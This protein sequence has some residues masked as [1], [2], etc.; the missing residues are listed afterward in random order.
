VATT[1]TRR[2]GAGAQPS[3]L[4]ARAHSPGDADRV[5][6]GATRRRLLLVDPTAG[7]PAERAKADALA[8]LG[9]EVTVLSPATIREGAR[10]VRS[11]PARQGAP[12]ALINGRL[13][14]KAPNRCVF[15]SGLS[16]ALAREPDV[17][18]VL[19]DESF[20]LTLQVLLAARRRWPRALRVAHSW[21]N[22]RCTWRRHGQPLLALYAFD[23][24]LERLVF[25]LSDAI[26]ARNEEATRVLRARGFAG[27]IAAIPWGVDT[28]AVRTSRAGAAIPALLPRPHFG[29][30][31]RLVAEK[32]VADLIAAL[33][34]TRGSAVIV[35][36]GP[37]RDRLERLA[38]RRGAA[39][40]VHF[41][42]A[43][44]RALIGAWMR[45]F[46]ALVLPSRETTGWKEQF[47]RVLVEA[48]AV[49]TPCVGSDSGAIPEVI[50]G[51]GAVYPPGD[52]RALA[53]ALAR[54]LG[55]REQFSAAALAAS[56]AFSWERF[57]E[58][59]ATFLE[60]L[61]RRP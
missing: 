35:G 11:P 13:V 27:P 41:A 42:G 10:I 60:S 43:A 38:R 3:G 21:Q 58:R 40:R 45:S 50:G 37:E 16:E 59:T 46:D 48:M 24:A 14:G 53:S 57:A 20:A 18:H 26:V 5:A 7:E 44:P 36:D 39:E 32:G 9:F 31:G 8:A 12:Y 51:A 61:G 4:I 25:K 52:E 6:P 55:E 19:S 15:T 47:G 33:E 34:H 1:W 2:G 22:I 54:V 17:V 23:T 28:S 49:G 29:F 56:E 30:V